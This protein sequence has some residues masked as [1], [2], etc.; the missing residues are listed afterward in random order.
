M[1]CAIRAIPVLAKELSLSAREARQELLNFLQR[2]WRGKRPVL[3]GKMLDQ[4]EIN[5][6]TYFGVAGL[7]ELIGASQVD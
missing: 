3:G 4:E 2:R 6:A 1:R 5:L 7:N